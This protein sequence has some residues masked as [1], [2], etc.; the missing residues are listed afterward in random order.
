MRKNDDKNNFL[1]YRELESESSNLD[2]SSAYLESSSAEI[3]FDRSPEN[4]LSLKAFT[5]KFLLKEFTKKKE[6]STQTVESKTCEAS[7]QTITTKSCEENKEDDRF[8]KFLFVTIFLFFY[9]TFLEI[10]YR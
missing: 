10:Y 6:A 1:S 9:L 3:S 7:T 4:D 2:S 5:N 8:F